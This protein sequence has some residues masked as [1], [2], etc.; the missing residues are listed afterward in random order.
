V[1]LDEA[2]HSVPEYLQFILHPKTPALPILQQL[3][4]L[5]VDFCVT[6]KISTFAFNIL[7]LYVAD[8]M[9]PC[10]PV[11]RVYLAEGSN[12]KAA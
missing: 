10:E 5:P 3:H 11:Y 9:S 1:P 6:F 12:L 2:Y 7:P 4:W 8:V